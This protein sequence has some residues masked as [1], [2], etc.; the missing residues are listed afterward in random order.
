MINFKFHFAYCLS[1]ES[2][3]NQEV[4]NCPNTFQ[5]SSCQKVIKLVRGR[6]SLEGF[7]FST[8][9]VFKHLSEFEHIQQSI[10]EINLFQPS[11]AFHIETRHLF[12]SA[13][14][15]TSFYM[16]RDTGLNFT[17][18]FHISYTGNHVFLNHCEIV[19]IILSFEHRLFLA[20]F[21]CLSS[22]SNKN[23]TF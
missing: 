13:K 19:T 17:N 1:L 23:K 11:V 9:T 4:L 21:D 16:K 18:G 7:A 8:S 6:W 5:S 10:Q 15:M 2:T 14:E 3:D 22:F 20:N 12:C